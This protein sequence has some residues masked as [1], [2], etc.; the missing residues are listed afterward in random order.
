MIV[1]EEE[2]IFSLTIMIVFSSTFHAASKHHAA[3]S[4]DN[5]DLLQTVAKTN[6]EN[7]KRK[8]RVDSEKPQTLKR[9]Y[10]KCSNL[11]QEK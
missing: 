5:D 11:K 2:S 9:G 1:S 4:G 3:I 6:K 7:G 10:Q 8:L